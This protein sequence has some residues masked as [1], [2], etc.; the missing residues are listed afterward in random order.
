MTDIEHDFGKSTARECELRRDR[1]TKRAV[2]H[3][4][5]TDEGPNELGVSDHYWIFGNSQQICFPPESL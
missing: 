4:A 3:R 1:F 5:M 2:P